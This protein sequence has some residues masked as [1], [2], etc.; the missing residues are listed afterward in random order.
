MFRGK[1]IARLFRCS[2]LSAKKSRGIRLLAAALTTAL[3]RCQLFMPTRGSAYFFSVLPNRRRLL[4]L[5]RFLRIRAKKR[6]WMKMGVFARRS[7]KRGSKTQ[8]RVLRF[9]VLEVRRFF[10]CALVPQKGILA[11]FCGVNERLFAVQQR[12][13]FEKMRHQPKRFIQIPRRFA[14]VV[15]KHGGLNPPC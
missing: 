14:G 11:G 12:V 5:R 6:C 13:E 15:Q 1:I 2:C 4:C 10:I 9:C 8:A 3:C 7:R